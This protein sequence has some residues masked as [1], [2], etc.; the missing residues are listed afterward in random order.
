MQSGLG[1]SDG[2]AKEDVACQFGGRQLADARN[3]KLSKMPASNESTSVATCVEMV[4]RSKLVLELESN[5][6]VVT[7]CC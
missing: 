2:R 4:L 1:I 7:N 3:P 5:H 6:S